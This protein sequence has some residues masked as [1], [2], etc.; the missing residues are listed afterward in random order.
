VPRRY[1]LF[2]WIA[3]VLVLN[4]LLLAVIPLVPPGNLVQTLVVQTLWGTVFG[5]TAVA[6]AW[7]TFGP[8]PFRW[9]FPLS[10][11]WLAMLTLAD[12]FNGWLNRGTPGEYII[13][14]VLL[15]CLWLLL[16]L[17]FWGIAFGFGVQLQHADEEESGNYPTKRQFGIRQVMILTAIVGILLGI[18]RIAVPYLLQEVW[19]VSVIAPV[20]AFLVV[21]EATMTLPLV[22][23]ALL[24][25][26]TVVG[27]VMAL[28]LIG[29]ITACEPSLLDMVSIAGSSQM[30]E[31]V[32]L[33]VSTAAS[34]LALL[35]I[36]RLNGYSLVGRRPATG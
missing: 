32:A 36:V 7:A 4:W 3:P 1:R 25:R 28:A 18:G 14:G 24:R 35:T 30:H 19:M 22:V 33:N 8:M 27:V 9:R 20:V 11:A 2:A 26:H 5:Q 29:A 23:A 15:L 17:L 34:T 31:I 13:V 12:A 6:A 21:A 16:Q 10:L